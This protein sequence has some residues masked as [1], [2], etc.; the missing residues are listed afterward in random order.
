[1][2]AFDRNDGATD[3]DIKMP[4]DELNASAAHLTISELLG[5]LQDYSQNPEEMKA[6]YPWAKG[7]VM[8]LPL[9]SWQRDPKWD[10]EQQVR[11]ISSIWNAVDIGTYLVNDIYRLVKNEAGRECFQE[12]SDALLDGQQRLGAIQAYV[13]NEF[14]VLDANGTPRF[15]RE[16][17]VPERR[18]F[19]M[20][21][22]VRA[23]VKTFDEDKLKRA[24]NLRAFGGTPH[25]EDER[26]V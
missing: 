18:R 20:T 13:L 6:S 21:T 11:F 24:Y 1:M 15:W 5:K 4:Q 10:R 22:F 7:F 2:Q 16:L 19:G 12:N 8:G 14:P 3:N 25:T 17:P 26:A 9:P 23:I